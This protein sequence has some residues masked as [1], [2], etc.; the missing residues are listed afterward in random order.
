MGDQRLAARYPLSL[1]TAKGAH[2]FLNSSYG[3]IERAIGAERTPTLEM[4]V[5]DATARGIVDGDTVRVFNGWGSLE[6]PAKVGDVVRPGVVSM[7]S[8]WWASPASRGGDGGVTGVTRIRAIVDVA[9]RRS[10]MASQTLVGKVGLVVSAVRGGPRPGEVRVVVGGIAH[11]YIAY[12]AVA[13][14]TGAEV[15]VINNR[16]ARQVDVE[17]WPSIPTSDTIPGRTERSE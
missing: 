14:P 9:R 10:R 17:P 6:L 3:N 7:P 11:Y 16:G 13:V 2:H 5:D 1:V 15:L 12:A 8:G 4:S